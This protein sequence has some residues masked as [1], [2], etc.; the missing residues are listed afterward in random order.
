MTD[1]NNPLYSDKSLELFFGDNP[2]PV[3]TAM[4]ATEM[5][6]NYEAALDDQKRQT[7]FW[8]NLALGLKNELVTRG[9]GVVFPAEEWLEKFPPEW[10]RHPWAN[11]AWL[12]PSFSSFDGI[13][14]MWIY[15]EDKPKWGEI[16][17]NWVSG[18]HG[19]ENPVKRAPLSDFFDVK[20]T[21]QYRPQPDI[22]ELEEQ[23]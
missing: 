3:A 6:N 5:R 19:F 16:S 7:E 12:Q 14:F 22:A 18:K 10:D 23:A 2:S 20:A 13:T 17:W 9:K 8:K 21:L 11:W 1:M 15:F 4:W